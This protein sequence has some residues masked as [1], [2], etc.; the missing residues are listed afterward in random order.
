M[1]LGF[2]KKMLRHEEPKRWPSSCLKLKRGI[3]LML[4]KNTSVRDGFANGSKLKLLEVH[5]HY[6]VVETCSDTPKKFFLP[7]C[8]FRSKHICQLFT[9]ENSFLSNRILL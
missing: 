4:L 8:V 7:K 6:L 9:Q 5:K 2:L 3:P 1:E